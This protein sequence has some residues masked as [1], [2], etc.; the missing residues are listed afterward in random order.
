[1]PR[2]TNDDRDDSNH[3]SADPQAFEPAKGKV[4]L[5]LFLE[6]ERRL[7]AYILTLLANRADADD[8]LQDA[9]MVMW[10]KFDERHPPD[11]FAAWGCRIAYFKVLDFLKKSLRSRVQFSQAMLDRV[12]ET[13]IEQAECLRLDERREALADCLEKLSSRDRELLALRFAPGATTQSTAAQVGRSVDS[14][15]KA[16]AKIRLALFECVN[17]AL[18]WQT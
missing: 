17:N 1:M 14:V 13:A 8:V 3:A 7:Y 18:A 10:D 2:N 6:N 4:F 11:D 16:L 15:Y 12:A 5:R 9:S